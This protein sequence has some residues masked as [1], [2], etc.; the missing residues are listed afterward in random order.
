MQVL[1][2]IYEERKGEEEKERR[3]KGRERNKEGGKGGVSEFVQA[4]TL[5]LSLAAAA[6][7]DTLSNNGVHIYLDDSAVHPG[8]PPWKDDPGYGNKSSCGTS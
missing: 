2:S 3:E 8:A 1:R 5:R 6:H 4:C 7:W